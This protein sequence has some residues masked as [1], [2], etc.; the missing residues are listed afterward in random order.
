MLA[1]GLAQGAQEVWAVTDLDNRASIGVCRRIG[2]RLLGIPHRWYH[3]P[4][5][6]FWLGARGDQVPSLEPDAS[7]AP[8]W[9]PA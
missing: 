7:L 1:R 4:S 8:N 6:M 2:M 9:S 5:T 3:E